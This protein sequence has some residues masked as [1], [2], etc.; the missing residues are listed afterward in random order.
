MLALRRTSQI[1]L[2]IAPFN[3]IA[4]N[5]YERPSATSSGHTFGVIHKSSLSSRDYWPYS[6]GLSGS[7]RARIRDLHLEMLDY[8]ADRDPE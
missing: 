7:Q 4:V 5:Q 6:P 1:T 8:S 3:I 2:K